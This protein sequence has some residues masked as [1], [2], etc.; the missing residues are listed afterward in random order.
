MREGVSTQERYVDEPVK[1]G[2]EKRFNDLEL[3]SF[4][5]MS[6]EKEEV[7]RELVKKSEGTVQIWIHTHYD[8]NTDNSP[9]ALKYKELRDKAI[10]ASNSDAMPI[11]SFIETPMGYEDYIDAYGN[12]YSKLMKGTVFVVPTFQD[13]SVP[14]ILNK[15]DVFVSKHETEVLNWDLLGSKLVDLGVKKVI[16][17]GRNFEYSQVDPETMTLAQDI[18]TE[19]NQLSGAKPSI[20]DKC[21]GDAVVQLDARGL[22]V[23]K[24]KVT[25]PEQLK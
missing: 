9:E 4:F 7:F 15:E 14:Y 10:A 16:I 6:P 1:E 25:Y 17:R 23:L 20:P 21:A 11:I 22:T 5:D 2:G 24:T 13:T 8:E 19:K 3:I 12:A 18:Y